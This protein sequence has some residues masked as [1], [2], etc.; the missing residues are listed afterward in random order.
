MNIEKSKQTKHSIIHISL[1]SLGV[2]I[3]RFF[4]L[5]RTAINTHFFD[6]NQMDI[7]ITSFR[8]PNTFRSILAEGALQNS[9]IPIYM[10]V[11]GTKNEKLFLDSF[12]TLFLLI[13][14]F[15]TSILIL[16]VPLF[17]PILT[18]GFKTY[19]IEKINS[20]IFL[21]QLIFPYLILISLTSFF[22]SILNSFYKFFAPNLN[23]AFFNITFIFIIII[24]A[25]LKKLSISTFIYAIL[26]SGFAQL[27]SLIPHLNRLGISFKPSFKFNNPYIKKVFKL[28]IPSLFSSSAYQLNIFISLYFL[29]LFPGSIT[30]SYIAQR[31]YQLPIGIFSVAMGQVFLTTFSDNFAKNEMDKLNKNFNYSLKVSF[32]IAVPIIGYLV[33]AGLPVLKL[34]FY[35]GKYTLNDIIYS[36]KFLLIYLPGLLFISNN[37]ILTSFYYSRKSFK[38]PVLSTLLS[39][40]IFYITVI[41]TYK[42]IEMYS[43]ALGTLISLIFQFL[44]LYVL[45]TKYIKIKD[46]NIFF[47]FK[48]LFSTTISFL[49]V[50]YIVKI[51]KWLNPV[52]INLSSLYHILFT[53]G[54]SLLYF[55]LF[56]LISLLLKI[57]EINKILKLKQNL[58]KD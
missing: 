42:T 18:P 15:V 8:I 51:Y 38:Q 46:Q 54:I 23:Q 16:F 20:T 29:S 47:Y 5:L 40:V 13:L 26:I 36:Y 34:I 1:S 17:M 21:S 6:A 50:F 11:K 24:F 3:S 9:F 56:V 41:F 33:S 4:G 32:L 52:Q 48:V 57:D 27:F 35:H 43:V 49:P 45:S 55:L 58:K 25:L 30:Y 37:R 31:I 22:S 44:F 12:F 10:E 19:S 53:I 28:F 14:F 2:F 39:L 7:Y